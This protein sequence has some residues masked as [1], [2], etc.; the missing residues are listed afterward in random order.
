MNVKK[1]LAVGII[2][3]SLLT[4]FIT[5]PVISIEL[6]NIDRET[7]LLEVRGL[8]CTDNVGCWAILV[9]T[10]SIFT[11]GLLSPLKYTIK[12]VY[13]LLN[14][15]GWEKDHIKILAWPMATKKKVLD[16]FDWVSEISKENDI[17]FFLFSGH[18]RQIQDKE[19]F[20]EPDGIDEE[21]VIWGDT[22][23]DEELNAELNKFKGRSVLAVFDSCF[24]GGM[25]DGT[26]DLC[27]EGRVVLTA[28]AADEI[29]WENSQH[30]GG[31]FSYYLTEGF[32][33]ADDNGNKNVSAEEA[34]NYAAPKTI[35][36]TE[37]YMP[38]SEHPQIFDG[39]SGELEIIDLDKKK[40]KNSLNLVTY[41]LR[42]LTLAH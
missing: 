36:W 32:K 8:K 10:G 37:E 5:V 39:C 23:S 34:F 35:F 30:N 31:V 17:I 27:A 38:S 15:Y 33:L 12:G 20:D 24:S 16:A 18:G 19:P 4:G 9:E 26:A 25:I 7:K 13:K 42:I 40:V 21:I 3:L 28:T 14:Q 22:L 6:N 41:P 1:W 11:H 29:S 2:S